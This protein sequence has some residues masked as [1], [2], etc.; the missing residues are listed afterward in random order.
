MYLNCFGPILRLHAL[1]FWVLFSSSLVADLCLAVWVGDMGSGSGSK[2]MESQVE[3]RK[4]EW[5]KAGC[6][7][8]VG[9]HKID[10]SFQ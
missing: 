3:Q 8:E 10:I 6:R 7:R 2:L 4:F 5:E 1:Y 9:A